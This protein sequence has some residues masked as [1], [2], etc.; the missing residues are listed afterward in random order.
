MG[1]TGI[2]VP[3]EE[4]VPSYFEWLSAVHLAVHPSPREVCMEWKQP[5]AAGVPG[6]H[7]EVVPKRM[8]FL[9]KV[10]QV[11]VLNQTYLPRRHSMW[12]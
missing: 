2:L 3:P 5:A 12:S 11:E 6:N 8:S 1:V 4:T 7:N 10:A 9:V